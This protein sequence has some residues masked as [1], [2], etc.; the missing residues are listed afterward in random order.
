MT[1]QNSVSKSITNL[2]KR[3]PKGEYSY[4]GSSSQ[5]SKLSHDSLKELLQKTHN[6]KIEFKALLL[7]NEEFIQFRKDVTDKLIN[8]WYKNIT[9]ANNSRTKKA[10]QAKKRE[11]MAARQ[12]I[13][14]AAQAVKKREADRIY[15]AKDRERIRLQ[16]QKAR[17]QKKLELKQAKARAKNKLQLWKELD[18]SPEQKSIL[19]KIAQ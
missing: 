8:N 3:Y 1:T 9:Q 7:A 12:K 15:W 17:E 18:L 16:A 10:L 13:E 2:I 11:E 14:L 19:R 5:L 6:N 4:Y